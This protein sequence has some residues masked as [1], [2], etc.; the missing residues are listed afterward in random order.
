MLVRLHG[1]ASDIP[2][3]CRLMVK[4]PVPLALSSLSASSSTMIPDP[5]IRSCDF[6]SQCSNLIGCHFL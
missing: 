6:M 4:L 5:C 2:R 3:R 1:V